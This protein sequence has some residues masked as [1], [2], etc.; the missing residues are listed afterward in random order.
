MLIVAFGNNRRNTASCY[1]IEG[2]KVILDSG[3]DSDR[4]MSRTAIIMRSYLTY[5]IQDDLAKH[6]IPEIWV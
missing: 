5:K 4:K 3:K 2:F 6:E 1:D